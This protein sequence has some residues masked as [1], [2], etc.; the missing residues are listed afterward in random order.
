MTKEYNDIRDAIT[1]IRAGK[2]GALR[3]ASSALPAALALAGY[4][5][6]DVD[7]RACIYTCPTQSDWRGEPYFWGNSLTIDT[8]DARAQVA[9]ELAARLEALLQERGQ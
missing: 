7:G 1:D 3:F 4:P 5:G 9:E 6:R 2:R 8:P